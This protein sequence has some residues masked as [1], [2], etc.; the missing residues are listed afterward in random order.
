MIWHLATELNPCPPLLTGS[1]QGPYVCFD[2]SVEYK[3]REGKE[4]GWGALVRSG[5]S[6]FSAVYEGGLHEAHAV[7]HGQLHVKSQN[8]SYFGG[9]RENIAS[10]WGKWTDSW[11]VYWPEGPVAPLHEPPE[12]WT[13]KYEGGFKDGYFHG[14]AELIWNNG[15]YYKGSWKEGRRYGRGV[16]VTSDGNN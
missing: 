16:Y 10:G 14:Y 3:L 2:V 4:T 6:G 11:T 8:F 15:A 1:H 12:P 5:S 9:W 7:G 13:M